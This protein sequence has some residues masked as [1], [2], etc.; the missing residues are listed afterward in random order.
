VTLRSSSLVKDCSASTYAHRLA[1]VNRTAFYIEDNLAEPIGLDDMCRAGGM[2][3]FHLHRV[4][5]EN[6]GT[7]LGRFLSGA[8]LKTALHLL[9]AHETRTMTVLEVA[10]QVGFEDAS[11]FSR[12]FQRRYG[13]TPSSLRQGNCPR[14]F[15]L[16]SPRAGLGGLGA[17]DRGV[18]VVSLPEFWIY[19]YEVGGMKNKSFTAEAPDGFKQL[20]DATRRHGIEGVPG[21]LALPTQSWLLREEACRLLCAFRSSRRL[22]LNGMTQ[23]FMPSGKWLRA[24]HTGPHATRWQTWNRLQIRQLRW[25][26]PRDGRAPFEEEVVPEPSQSSAPEWPTFDVYFPC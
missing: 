14:E 23:H 2:S 18:T 3:K 26:Q 1:T 16:L 6:V 8:R 13:L 15:P 20:E 11:A 21:E 7:T 24:R 19:G 5:E 9:L 22:D 25:G 12:S 10:L 4:F 17:L